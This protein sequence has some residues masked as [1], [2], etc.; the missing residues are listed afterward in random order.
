MA[1]FSREPPL[2]TKITESDSKHDLLAYDEIPPWYQDNDCIRHGH[3]S[4]TNDTGECFR[5]WG[6]FHNETANIYSHL[7]PAILSLASQGVIYSSFRAVFP[8]STT[9]DY[10]IVAFHLASTSICLGL[11]SFYHT[12]MNHSAPFSDLWGRLDYT[13]II[14]LILGDFVSGV[15]VGF[16]CEPTLQNT[17]WTMV[18]SRAKSFF[19][20][21][22]V[23]LDYVRT[24]RMTMIFPLD[25]HSRR[26]NSVHR[27]TSIL[28]K[29]SIP[30]VS[31]LCFR[32]NRPVGIC[33]NY[34]RIEIGSVRA[35][36]QTVR[37]AL[38]LRR[39]WA[40]PTRRAHLWH[41]VPRKAL[42]WTI[43]YLG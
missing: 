24:P 36:Q 20:S 23:V 15:Y 9:S 26:L 7:F 27:G 34:P 37:F 4:V 12:L 8:Q 30:P 31:T 10:L 19:I 38:L 29:P 41:A 13:G 18:C 21:L 42:P 3:R 40:D 2:Q 43:R 35:T 25:R 28:P 14:V 1:T 16:Y 6:Y 32:S 11:S 33:S 39:R 22:S 17:Y 5:S